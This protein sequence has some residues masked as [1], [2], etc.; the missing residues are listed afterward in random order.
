MGRILYNKNTV[1]ESGVSAL[2]DSTL[3]T[4]ELVLNNNNDNPGL[5]MSKANGAKIKV[6]G[7]KNVKMDENLSTLSGAIAANDSVHDAISKLN[8]NTYTKQEVD[9][10]ISQSGTFDPSQYY[11]KNDIDN[12]HYITSGDAKTQIENYH[13]TTSG[14]VKTQVENYHYITSGDAKTQ[15]ENYHYITSADTSNAAKKLDHNVTLSL[16]GEVKGSAVTDFSGNAVA[17]NTYKTFTTVTSL[18]NL[19]FENF[20]TVATIGANATLTISS[21]GLVSIPNGAVREGHLLIQNSSSSNIA[22]TIASDSRV[23]TTN[24]TT[25]TVEGNGIGELNA[26]ITNNGGTYTVYIITS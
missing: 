1:Q 2:F 3:Y 4:G 12:K 15:I 6:N 10:K 23:K 18:S 22:I 26:L 11:T 24:G 5:W 19:T 25:F 8:N 9:D 20:L 17:M 14:N 21:T 16:S 13:Y 7:A